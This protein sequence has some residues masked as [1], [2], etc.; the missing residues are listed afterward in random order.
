MDGNMKTV[1]KEIKYWCQLFLLPVYG[2]SFLIPRSKKIWVFGSTFGKR[3]ADNPKYFFLYLN[4]YHSE[5]V[6]AIWI[7]KN[8]EIARLLI[9]NKLEAYYLYSIK[10]IWHCL[11]A[12]VYIYDNYSKDICYTL[13]GGAKKINLWHG[14]PLKK[15]QKDNLFDYVRNPRSFFE[16]I[17]GIPRRITDEKS[18]HYVLTTSVNLEEIFSSAFRTEHILVAGYPRNDILISDYIHNI[19]TEDEQIVVSKL[20]IQKVTKKIVLYMPTF[21]DSEDKFFDVVN[22][23]EFNEFLK[24]NNIYLCIKLHPKSKLQRQ[25]QLIECNNILI[26][27]YQ[28]DPYPLLQLSDILLT[29]YSS[30]YFDFLLTKKPIVFFPYD[31][32]EYLSKSRDFYFEYQEITPGGKAFNQKELEELLLKESTISYEY[33]LITRMVHDTYEGRGSE[34]LFDIIYSMLHQTKEQ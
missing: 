21:R 27:N 17:Y 11:R 22:I 2:L 25:F 26:A 19:L 14:I 1:L 31:Y 13:S 18:S 7:T 4:Q 16:K 24:Q 32:D 20:K 23:R 9:S 28:V 3:F 29:D 30:I 12:K 8:K 33:D 10:G 6:R 34:H 15:I 5:H